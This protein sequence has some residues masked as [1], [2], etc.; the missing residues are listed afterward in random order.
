MMRKERKER[1]DQR[2]EERQESEVDREENQFCCYL[3][4]DPSKY[5]ASITWNPSYVFSYSLFMQQVR[6]E[7]RKEK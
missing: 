7:G 6:K 3:Q 1:S 5:K 4:L 2:K